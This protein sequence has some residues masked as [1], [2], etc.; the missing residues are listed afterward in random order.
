MVDCFAT[1]CLTLSP[2]A[3]AHFWGERVLAAC[4]CKGICVPHPRCVEHAGRQHKRQQHRYETVLQG[5]DIVFYG[6][7]LVERLRGTYGS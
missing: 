4:T 3:T 1:L 7:S 6:D 5:W 2:L